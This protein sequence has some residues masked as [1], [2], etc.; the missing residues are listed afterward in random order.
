MKSTAR[1]WSRGL[2][3]VLILGAASPVAFSYE[4]WGWHAY[5]AYRAYHA[6]QGYHSRAGYASERP[7]PGGATAKGMMF[8]AQDA[9]PNPKLTPGA[10]SSAVTQANIDQTICRPGGYTKSVRPPESYTEKLKGRLIRAYGYEQQVGGGADRY[11]NYELDHLVPLSIGGNPTSPKN[12]WPEPHVVQGGWGSYAKDRLE[13][14]IHDL[15]CAHQLALAQA[16]S[17]MATN[18][19]ATYKQLVGPTPD[20]NP[21][22]WQQ[23]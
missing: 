17:M 23:H 10:L 13:L 7:N 22:R 12:L 3:A 20:P 19:V 1:A 11:G 14:K 18:W 5:H 2:A 21:M 4:S 8:P 9:L 16:Q 15:V 6:Y